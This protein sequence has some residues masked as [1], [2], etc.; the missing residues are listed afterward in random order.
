MVVCFVGMLSVGL[1]RV[2]NVTT[3]LTSITF[4]RVLVK[5]LAVILFTVVQVVPLHLAII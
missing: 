3:V 2:A 5:I 1:V 4:T